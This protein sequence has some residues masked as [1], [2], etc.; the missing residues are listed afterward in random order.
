MYLPN[1]LTK[2]KKRFSSK[3]LLNI[4]LV[5]ES[6]FFQKTVGEAEAGMPSKVREWS[7]E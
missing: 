5:I 6:E 4:G 3:F 1:V 2:E 7:G